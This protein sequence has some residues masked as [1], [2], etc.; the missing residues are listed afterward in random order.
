MKITFLEKLNPNEKLRNWSQARTFGGTTKTHSLYIC[1]FR[2]KNFYLLMG[3]V[4]FV[5]LAGSVGGGVGLQGYIKQ[6]TVDNGDLGI[7]VGKTTTMMNDQGVM[8]TMVVSET[9][10][11]GGP[12]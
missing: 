7:I 12:R 9:S 1:G 4:G 6:K 11:V 8:T 3:G 2:R 5:V 10:F